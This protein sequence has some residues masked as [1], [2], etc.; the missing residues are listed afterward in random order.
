MYVEFVQR[1]FIP[2]KIIQI[3]PSHR[4]DVCLSDFF[5]KLGLSLC[6]QFA[7]LLGGSVRVESV[8]GVGSTFSVI[9]PL[10]LAQA[11]DDGL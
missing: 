6:K 2:R 1:D 7:A 8:P 5:G 9:I 11:S 4:I 10:A 3:V